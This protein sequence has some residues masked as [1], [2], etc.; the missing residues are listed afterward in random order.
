MNKITLE[1][2]GQLIRVEYGI[3]IA[4]VCYHVVVQLFTCLYTV[5]HILTV[6]AAVSRLV[7]QLAQV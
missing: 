2:S 1:T 6:A 3:A 4:S 7:H 5:H